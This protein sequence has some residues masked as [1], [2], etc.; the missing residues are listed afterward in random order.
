MDKK[1][2]LQFV[3]TATAH[4]D[5]VFEQML[6]L[7]R[8]EPPPLPHVPGQMAPF[9]PGIMMAQT[10]LTAL[11]QQE[12]KMRKIGQMPQS[13]QD[14]ESKRTEDMRQALQ[15]KL[16]EHFDAWYARM[17]QELRHLA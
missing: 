3:Q 1:F 13:V 8:P 17:K 4:E 16:G 11:L 9:D 10:A 2:L 6:V 7:I 15:E 5:Q 14:L 12:S